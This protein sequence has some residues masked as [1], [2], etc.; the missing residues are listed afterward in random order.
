MQDKWGIS[1]NSMTTAAKTT[2]FALLIWLVLVVYVN[3][4][5][6]AGDSRFGLQL[7]ILYYAGPVFV[8]LQYLW[9]VR[10]GR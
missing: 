2:L 10:K 3:F 5:P 8:L 6:E 1:G 4:N 7:T 9:L